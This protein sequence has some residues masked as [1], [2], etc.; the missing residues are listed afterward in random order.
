MYIRNITTYLVFE[1]VKDKKK[2]FEK[3]VT[4]NSYGELILKILLTSDWN[5]GY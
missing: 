4:I 3:S 2:K 5:T 1:Q